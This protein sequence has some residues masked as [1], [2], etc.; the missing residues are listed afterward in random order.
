MPNIA[1][2]LSRPWLGLTR[3]AGHVRR[4]T[5]AFGLALQV[6]RERRMLATT[7]RSKTWASTPAMRPSRRSARSGTCRWTVCASEGVSILPYARV[8]AATDAGCSASPSLLTEMD[9]AAVYAAAMGRCP[10]RSSRGREGGN[11]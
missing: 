3:I 4:L 9:R 11:D 2:T 6:R 5:S 1:L 8:A 10:Y 7:A